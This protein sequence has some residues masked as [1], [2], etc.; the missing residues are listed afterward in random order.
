[1]QLC[2]ATA[3]EVL[4]AASSVGPLRG[5]MTQL[6]SGQLVSAV[7]LSKQ[8]MHRVHTERFNLRK[9][10]KVEC[11]EQ[12]RVEIKNRFAALE[13]LDP[14]VNINRP[15]ETIRENIK[16]SAKVSLG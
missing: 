4:Q 13:N 12:Y 5:Y 6:S 10:N 8:T 2:H 7:Q 9:L 1:M 16:I 11:K 14:A 15:W 3:E